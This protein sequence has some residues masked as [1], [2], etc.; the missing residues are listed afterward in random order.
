MSKGFASNYRIV[1]LASFVIAGFAGLGARLVWLQVYGRGELLAYARKNR[2]EVIKLHARRGDIL[3]ANG[4]LLA[5]SLPYWD[6]GVDP[7]SVEARDAGKFPRLAALLGMPLP[8]L[9][10][11]LTTRFLPAATPART[12]EGVGSA[13]HAP[14]AGAASLVFNFP[15]K[16]ASS[17]APA[18]KAPAAARAEAGEDETELGD[19]DEHGLRPI[20]W[21]DFAGRGRHFLVSDSVH[22]QI[23]KLG[24][25]GVYGTREYRRNYP[26]KTLAAHV[27]GFVSGEE[28]PVSGIEAYMDFYLRG[29]NGW[30][31]TEKDAKAHELAQF[32]T[33]DVPASDGLTVKLSIDAQVQ[34]IAENEVA[35]LVR[36]YQPQK[37]TIIVSDPRTGFIKALANYPSFNPNDAATGTVPDVAALRN[38]AG[39][40]QYEP[41]SVFKIVASGGALND[42]LVTPDT[43]FDCGLT[44]IQYH[45]LV[46][47]LPRENIGDHFGILTVRQILDRSSNRGAAQLGM[48][49]GRER[50]MQ[51]VRAYGFGAPTG[52]PMAGEISGAAGPPKWDGLTITRMPMGQSVAVTPLQIHMA[53]GVI[54]SGGVLLK[55][56]VITQVLDSSGGL[57]Y[58]FKRVEVRRVLSEQT[59]RTM[60]QILSGVAYKMAGDS[61]GGTGSL[62]AIP[63]YEVA[64]KTGT[65]QKPERVTLPNGKV[66]TRMSNTHHVASFVGFFPASNPQV[67]I[68]IIVDDAD[69]HAPKGEIA[70]GFV[71]AP[72]FKNIGEQ[73]IP[74]LDIRPPVEPQTR[75]LL[76]MEGG[77]R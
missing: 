5:T 26:D 12:P 63:G 1:L 44:K 51:Y 16:P 33:R 41:G 70:G 27:I 4:N 10:P 71:A 24:V 64:G 20:H 62:A 56:Q 8:Q 58:S 29:Q 13:D 37:V 53:M 67:A 46:L 47:D 50:F 59:A 25:S 15:A 48:L 9:L 40:D 6:M 31:E 76:A 65:G 68:S 21:M 19:A 54:A 3:D 23:T 2:R 30:I 42:G 32:R 39:T 11:I 69:A 74:Y 66:V 73:L 55:P 61:E 28:H 45:G 7:Q 35:A 18:A 52:F 75:A 22:D 43:T 72:S 14:T 49:L 34:Q 38:V 17:A 57:V 36:K 60:A 77:R